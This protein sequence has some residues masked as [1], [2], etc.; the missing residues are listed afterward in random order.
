MKSALLLLTS[1]LAL[2]ILPSC[3]TTGGGSGFTDYFVVYTG[4]GIEVQNSKVVVQPGQE[5]S[6]AT[7]VGYDL[8]ARTGYVT[9]ASGRTQR[10]KITGAGFGGGQVAIVLEGGG[11]II[12][13][14]KTGQVTTAPP[15]GT[16]ATIVIKPVE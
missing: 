12:V 4:S 1:I 10:L 13:N 16:E 2:S 8:K 3:T 5:D 15:A 7:G 14:V 9:Y 11:R 6:T